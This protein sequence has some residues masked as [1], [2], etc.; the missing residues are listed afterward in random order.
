MTIFDELESQVR[1]YSRSFP[2]V[3][4][5]AEG[6]RLYASDGRAWLDFLSGA[7]ALN[8]GHNPVHLVDPV[9]GYLKGKGVISSL[10][11]HTRAKAEF[12]EAL[13]DVILRPR[14]LDYVVQF[15]GPTGT[16]AVEASL[17]LARL[18]TGRTNI[19]AFTNGYHGVSL[20]ALAA[21]GN[22]SKRAAA[23]HPLGFITRLPYDGYL[24]GVSAPTLLDRLLKDPGSGIDLPAAI[25]VETIQGEGGLNVASKDWLRQIQD[26]ARHHGALL[27]IDDIQAGCGRSGSFFSFEDLGIAP[28]IICLSKSIGGIGL[29]LSLVLIARDLDVWTPGQHNGTFRGNN[30]AFV[31]ARAALEYYWSTPDFEN[32]LKLKS[33][34]FERGLT[35]IASRFDQVSVRGRG[36]MRGL[37]IA[38][39]DAATNVSRYCFE[40][41]LIC[42]TCGPEDHVVKLLPPLTISD[43][44]LLEGI[45]IIEN[46]V[47]QLFPSLSYK[48]RLEGLQPIASQQSAAIQGNR[49]L[50][51]RSIDR[52][53]P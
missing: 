51:A 24:D 42:E 32:S 45:D 10:D 3:F 38:D 20:G 18:K 7:G 21:T 4:D 13:R 8:Y 52:H 15:V 39:L 2:A 17:K 14:G 47:S 27:I 16:N 23:G 44:D 41:G 34:L 37:A 30:L 50:C 43:S 22:G 6:S 40:A 26:T 48:K 1:T 19:V 29:P 33:E 25:I 53:V 46:A 49:V 31:A 5:F 12:L 28:D 36:L 35:R 11:L 9:I